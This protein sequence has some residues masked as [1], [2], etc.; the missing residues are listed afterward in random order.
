MSARTVVLP[1]HLSALLDTMSSD[2]GV[3]SSALVNQAVFNWA[4]VNGYAVPSQ[5]F[6]PPI[7]SNS[8]DE[9][10]PGSTS[11]GDSVEP[12]ANN[13]PLR[14]MAADRIREIM[15]DVDARAASENLPNHL[16]EPIALPAPTIAPPN[17]APTEPE[18]DWE[19]E[20]SDSEGVLNTASWDVDDLPTDDSA[21]DDSWE[22]GED[23][24]VSLSAE[25]VHQSTWSEQDQADFNDD[26]GRLTELEDG[27][28]KDADPFASRDHAVLAEEQGPAWLKNPS[29]E[30]ESLAPRP[31]DS[32]TQ[33]KSDLILADL[34]DIDADALHEAPGA[35]QREVATDTHTLLSLTIEGEKTVDVAQTP[36]TIGRSSACDLQLLSERVSRQHAKIESVGGMGFRIV[37]NGSSNGI[38]FGPERVNT[39]ALRDGDI[40]RIGDRRVRA[41]IRVNSSL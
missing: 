41:T 9:I 29:P 26:P 14:K 12:P 17:R 22:G 32:A 19:D 38:W 30:S 39:R 18:L 37:D 11:A 15:A 20:D 13:E 10:V 8:S 36:F 5:A 31:S 40:V 4:R 33:N 7:A 28:P 35:A 16:H 21:F 3:N 23:D 24:E 27:D 25:N 1:E 6:E 2:M 34:D